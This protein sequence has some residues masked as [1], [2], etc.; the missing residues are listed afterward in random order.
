MYSQLLPTSAPDKKA[1]EEGRAGFYEHPGIN[2]L[3][4]PNFGTE[5]ITIFPNISI[6]PLANGYLF[7]QFWPLSHDRM[8][9]EV[10][11][12]GRNKPRNVREEFAMAHT[13]AATR[14]VVVEDMAMC[15]LQQIG[16]RSGGKT[17]Q[18]FGQNEPLLRMFMR[19]YEAFL[20]GGGMTPR[21]DLADVQV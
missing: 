4:I 9:T 15:R 18:N 3:N 19:D 20:A 16:L 17:H 13:L 10:R 14:D 6:Q 11:I 21:A 1:I 2:R 8:R 5:A 12:Y 7:Y